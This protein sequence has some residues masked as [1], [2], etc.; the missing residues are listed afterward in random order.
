MGGLELKQTDFRVTAPGP[1]CCAVSLRDHFICRE[2]TLESR[3]IEARL[4]AE[5]LR[6]IYIYKE[7]VI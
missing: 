1:L 4:K 5:T 2:R 3:A 7:R 6:K